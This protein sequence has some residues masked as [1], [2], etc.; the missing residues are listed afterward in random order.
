[1]D[2]LDKLNNPVWL[3]IGAT[4]A[5]ALF[6]LLLMNIGNLLHFLLWT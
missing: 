2:L 6:V 3:G 4:V 5:F 1:M